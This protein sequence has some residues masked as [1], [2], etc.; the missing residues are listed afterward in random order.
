MDSKTAHDDPIDQAP[1][2]S[3][4]L[5][6]PQLE[7]LQKDHKHQ[8]VDVALKFTGGEH[9]SYTEEEEKVVFRKI[10]RYMLP[11]LCFVNFV[12]FSD[13]STLKYAAIMGIRTDTHLNPHT[14][15]YSWVASVFNAGYIFGV[16]PSTYLLARLPTGKMTSFMVIA[17][18]IVLA[19]HAAASSYAGLV[20]LR[21]LLGAFESSVTPAFVLI[22]SRWWPRKSQARRVGYWLLFNGVT[23]WVI[24]PIAY[25][26]TGVTNAALKSWQILYLLLGLITV[27]LGIALFYFLPDTQVNARFLNERQKAIAIESLRPNKQGIGTNVFRWY[28]VREAFR[29]PR[30]YLFFLWSIFLNI[31]DGGVQAF[32]SIVVTS[33]GFNNRRALLL[34][35]PAGI[36]SVS[37]NL[38]FCNLSDRYMDRTLFASLALAIPM[39]GCIMLSTIPL[40]AAPALLVGYYLIS[41]ALAG[42]GLGMSLI[43]ANT[44]GY[45][46][47]LTVN[48]LQI[49]A[50]AGGNWI[51]PQCYFAREAPVYLTGK[52]LSAVFY[53]CSIICLMLI[54]MLNIWENKRRDKLLAERGPTPRLDNQEFMDLT[55]FEQPDFRYMM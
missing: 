17:W 45:T 42:W 5:T 44:V 31:P 50:Y 19:C 21:F 6:E 23:N 51:G 24:A 49:L 27:C 4:P 39:I 32:G 34:D 11:L 22:S 53:G 3:Q 52:I 10:D 25:G 35:M 12:Q 41:C 28:Q 38:I 47:K 46:K 16:F 26:L 29:D 1:A 14:Q 20:V 33:F 8:G 40:S 7:A 9:L 13:K 43:S 2:F 15:Q 55:D 30:T 54:R 48:G 36:A 18:G 37:A